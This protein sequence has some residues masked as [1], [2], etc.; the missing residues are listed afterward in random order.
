MEIIDLFNQDDGYTSSTTLNIN[1]NEVH[2]IIIKSNDEQL[3][4]LK[5]ILTKND[6]S[7]F[8]NLGNSDKTIDKKDIEIIYRD[9]IL[10]DNLGVAENFYFDNLPR[11]KFSNLI[12]WKELRV[13]FESVKNFYGIDCNFKTKVRDLSSDNKK[14]LYICKH[15]YKNPKTII[16]QE[17]MEYLS[18]ENIIKVNKIIHSFIN[19]GGTVIYITKQWEEALR[20]SNCITAISKKKILGRMSAKEAK[21]N[22]RK[23]LSLIEGYHYKEDLDK[24][25]N[26]VLSAVFKSAEYLTSEYE[27]K[28]I[29]KFLAKELTEVVDVDGCLISLIDSPTK[30]IIDNYTYSKSQ[31]NLPLLKDEYILEAASQKDIYYSNIRDIGFE[32]IFNSTVD[33]KTIISVPIIIR[34]Q[35]SGLISIYYKNIYTQTQKE[36]MYLLTFARH[37]A[38][39]I[40]GT[41]LLGRSALLQ[42]SHHRIKNNL[43]SIITLI[44]MQKDYLENGNKK[45]V[46]EVFLKIISSIKSI[47][48]IHDLLSKNDHGGSI[49]NLKVILENLIQNMEKGDIHFNMQLEDIFISY[50]KATSVAIIVNELLTNV[51]KHAFKDVPKTYS[52]TVNVDLKM[53]KDNIVLIMK[54]N[55]IG[56]PEDFDLKNVNS[57]GIKILYGIV[58]NEFQ[59][60]IYFTR[61][62]GTTV[63]IIA[64]RKWMI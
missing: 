21:S 47:A 50:S 24:D 7:Q 42:E 38:I 17:P 43:Q 6:R 22:P 37:A 48:S 16:I 30:T 62:N 57:I 60:D 1:Y 25:S 4:F 15:F 58:N 51:K 35:L 34:T 40:E 20:I 19:N 23:L 13:S 64:P 63:E 41:R 18:S 59:G 45:P 2:S 9:P 53:I 26:N 8:F 52:K 46:N 10:F 55:G 54:D 61:N 12:D 36:T 5:S 32:S 27:L 49:I 29:L 44:S 33:F 31:V 14:F 39:A 11:K 3:N 56:I 28:D